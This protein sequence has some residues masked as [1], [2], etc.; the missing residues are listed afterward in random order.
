MSYKITQLLIVVF[1]TAAAAAAVAPAQEKSPRQ[2]LAGPSNIETPPRDDARDFEI[3][4]NQ[5]NLAAEGK[6]TALEVL[7]SV[8]FDRELNRIATLVE[9]LTEDRQERTELAEAAKKERTELKAEL[10]AEIEAIR[11]AESDKSEMDRQL[12]LVIRTYR[13]PLQ[14]LLEREESCRE[15]IAQIDKDRAELLHKQRDLELQRKLVLKGGGKPPPRP[16]NLPIARPMKP[17]VR[18]EVSYENLDDLIN[19]IKKY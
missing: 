19:D 1:L 3:P 17:N 9:L 18:K 4:L 16:S 5:T 12:V 2:T 11:N 10:L 8:T 14:A 13:G 6:R 15:Q 7:A